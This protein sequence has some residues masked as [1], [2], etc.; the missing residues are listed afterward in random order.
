VFLNARAEKSRLTSDE[1]EALGVR[2]TAKGDDDLANVQST[3]TGITETFSTQNGILF[4][5]GNN[6]GNIRRGETLWI[7][8]QAQGS[9]H[10]ELRS[11]TVNSPTAVQESKETISVR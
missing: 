5:D 1:A 3:G 7:Q 9:H 10:L 11:S 2:S 6:K 8:H 4:I